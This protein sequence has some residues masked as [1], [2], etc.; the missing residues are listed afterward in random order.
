MDKI[1]TSGNVYGLK[2]KVLGRVGPDPQAELQ[3]DPA[4]GTG[5]FFDQAIWFLLVFSKWDIGNTSLCVALPKQANSHSSGVIYHGEQGYNNW[6][7]PE[8]EK[9]SL[10]YLHKNIRFLQLILSKKLGQAYLA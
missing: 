10:W 9:E 5:D 3:V 1:W 8:P 2:P 7:G 4:R 6:Q